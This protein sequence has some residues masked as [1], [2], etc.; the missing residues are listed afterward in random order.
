MSIDDHSLDTI[1][2]FTNV[3]SSIFSITAELFFKQKQEMAVSLIGD[4]VLCAIKLGFIQI[5]I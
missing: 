3:L 1:E 2:V 5:F 4:T